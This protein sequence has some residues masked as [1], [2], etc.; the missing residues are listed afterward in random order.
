MH[1]ADSH[2]SVTGTTI[3]LGLKRQ[4]LQTEQF[5]NILEVEA[6]EYR[7]GGGGEGR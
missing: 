5:V 1:T 2:A 6:L 7:A 3:L 4:R